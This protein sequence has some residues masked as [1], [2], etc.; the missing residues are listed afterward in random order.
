VSG[1]V[2]KQLAPR[3]GAPIGQQVGE[4]KEKFVL[5]GNRHPV[6]LISR[7]YLRIDR[8]GKL[9]LRQYVGRGDYPTSILEKFS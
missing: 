2:E 3:V 8:L 5:G 7:Y 1:E 9:R 4:G 6:A